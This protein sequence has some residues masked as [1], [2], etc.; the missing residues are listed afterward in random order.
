MDEYTAYSPLFDKGIYEAIDLTKCVN[1]RTSF[2]G[3][4]F[5]S[6]NAQIAAMRGKGFKKA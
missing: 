2:G 6:V 1:D 5:E 3:A 4:G